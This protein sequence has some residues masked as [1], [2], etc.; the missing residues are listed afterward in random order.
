M[1]WPQASAIRN[2]D[3]QLQRHVSRRLLKGTSPTIAAERHQLGIQVPVRT[4]EPLDTLARSRVSCQ[5]LPIFERLAW[6]TVDVEKHEIAL[7]IW[8]V[9]RAFGSGASPLG[10]RL[11]RAPDR[12]RRV[13]PRY[14]SDRLVAPHA[15]LGG[16]RSRNDDMIAGISTAGDDEKQNDGER[17]KVPYHRRCVSRANA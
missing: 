10:V 4:A 13:F 14:L 15:V 7:T 8:E 2:G 11:G 17:E 9:A 12:D 6:V 3:C 1:R 5:E 16:H